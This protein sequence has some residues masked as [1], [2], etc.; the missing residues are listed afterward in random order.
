MQTVVPLLRHH[1]YTP[2]T[3]DKQP[4]PPSK[5]WFPETEALSPQP[6][7]SMPDGLSVSSKQP[8]ALRALGAEVWWF[9]VSGF[10]V[11]VFCV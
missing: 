10:R 4:L 9:R 1:P 6:P 8:K 5:R 11:W 2:S 7:G 3:P